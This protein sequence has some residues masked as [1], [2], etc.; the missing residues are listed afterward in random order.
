MGSTRAWQWY[1]WLNGIFYLLSWKR[2]CLSGGKLWEC[3]PAWS[4]WITDKFSSPSLFPGPHLK[5]HL[6]NRLFHRACAFQSNAFVLQ[7]SLGHFKKLIIWGVKNRVTSS[8]RLK[9]NESLTLWDSF[10]ILFIF[11]SW[12]ICWKLKALDHNSLIDIL[13]WFS[14]ISHNHSHLPQRYYRRFK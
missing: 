5:K 4:G 3:C 7:W 6:V 10:L 11:I 1:R 12:Y 14:D 8:P 9:W 2:Y 13:L